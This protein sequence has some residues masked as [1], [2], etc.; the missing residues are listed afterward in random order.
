MND[1]L[2]TLTVR[3]SDGPLV[4]SSV[5]LSTVFVDAT[6]LSCLPHLTAVHLANGKD[7]IIASIA[8][9]PAASQAGPCE[10]YIVSVWAATA[11][12]IPQ[13]LRWLVVC[14]SVSSRV[15]LGLMKLNEV[16]SL[17]YAQ[18]NARNKVSSRTT[19]AVNVPCFT[20]HVQ[21]STRREK[22]LN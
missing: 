21:L 1:E 6:C 14:V 7:N 19:T 2:K 17:T 11:L 18:R 5:C 3:L 12:N 16:T 8:L 13:L 20:A 9:A 4:R 22:L 10:T 15:T